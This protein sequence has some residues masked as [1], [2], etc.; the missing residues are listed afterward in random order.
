M[1]KV[2]KCRQNIDK[3][4]TPSVNSNYDHYFLLLVSVLTKPFSTYFNILIHK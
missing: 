4:Y 3:V 2:K 1:T